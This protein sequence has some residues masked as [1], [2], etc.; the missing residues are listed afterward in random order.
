[1]KITVLLKRR[2]VLSRFFYPGNLTRLFLIFVIAGFYF[3]CARI[4][5]QQVPAQPIVRV[6]IFE[7]QDEIDFKPLNSFLVLGRKKGEK[8]SLSETGL[9]RAKIANSAPAPSVYRILFVQTFQ[10]ERAEK[11]LHKFR[12]QNIRVE[13]ITAGDALYAGNKAI[14]D[15]KN[16]RVV[17]AKDFDN[18]RQAAAYLA[19]TPRLAGGKVV[20][21]KMGPAHGFITLVSPSGKTLVIENALRIT[22]S[23]VV[24]KNVRVGQGF[25]WERTEDRTFTGEMEF[26]IDASGKLTAVNV[27]T[28]DN[29]LRGVL[30]GEMTSSFPLQAL[31]A[32]AIVARTLFLYNFNR[33]HPDEP[34]DVCDDVHCQSFV[35]IGQ[36]APS[37][38]KAVWETKGFVLTY[39]HRL[40]STPYSALCGGHTENAENVWNSDGEP[41]LVGVFDV[42]KNEELLRAFDLSKE[43]N[44]KKWI[45]SRPAV[46]CNAALMGDP[47]FSAYSDKYFRWQEKYSAKELG[48]IIEEKTGEQMGA[49]LD[50]VP[51]RRGVS[52][53]II[54]LQVIG[55]AASFTLHNELNIRRA[56]ARKTLYSA[57]FVV[58]KIPAADGRVQKFILKGA[59]WGHGVGM[60]QIGAGMMALQGKSVGDILAHYYRGTRITKFY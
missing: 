10:K 24:L 9:W 55:S 57:C 30:P 18:E 50:I 40:C 43:A 29:Y 22:K 23:P 17:L 5:Y 21:E 26:R 32:Q 2:E 16:Y 1:M 4:P 28:M 48:Q 12:S 46:N 34:F 14:V 7:G 59:G 39:D 20:R 3:S 60:C 56:L 27:L 37:I 49:L 13:L 44:V 41:Y 11:V 8:F 58:D 53:R 36:D 54:D 51:L 42:L 52:G 15:R 45:E 6:G 19:T 47:H 35:G 31:K 25:Q 33:K 38:R